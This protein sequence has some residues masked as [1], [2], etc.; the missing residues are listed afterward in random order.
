MEAKIDLS[1]KFYVYFNLV[2]NIGLARD[3]FNEIKK[4]YSF[5]ITYK[6]HGTYVYIY[7]DSQKECDLIKNDE[8]FNLYQKYLHQDLKTSAHKVF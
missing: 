3:F 2:N 4:L 6:V 8:T 7:F 1:D 5:A